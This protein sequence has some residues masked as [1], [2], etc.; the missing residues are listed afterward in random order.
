VTGRAGDAVFYGRYK[1]R[2][3]AETLRAF[4]DRR[5]RGKIE[6]GHEL[7]VMFTGLFDAPDA[8]ANPNPLN[9]KG[10]AD[11]QVIVEASGWKPTEAWNEARGF[12]DW[13]DAEYQ[14]NDPLQFDDESYSVMLRGELYERIRP[15]GY[16][17]LKV[18]Y[19][20]EQEYLTADTIIAA[21]NAGGFRT[22]DPTLLRLTPFPAGATGR[23]RLSRAIGYLPEPLR[24][25][26]DGQEGLGRRL[27]LSKT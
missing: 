13:L 21:I 26:I 4:A 15:I 8:F 14:S 3:F 1:I 22:A 16:A 17:I 10:R 18:L 12:A 23:K 20:R 11:W 25:L 7:W 5:D 19:N 24:R 27:H 6:P 9:A 2:L